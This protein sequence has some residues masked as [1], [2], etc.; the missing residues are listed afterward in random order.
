MKDSIKK[1]WFC[2]I[3]VVVI[4]IA[5]LIKLT[6]NKSDGVGTAG[7]SL[8]EFEEINLGMSNLTVNKIIDKLDEWNDNNI[9]NKCCKE[10]SKSSQNSVYT[11]SYKYYGE[12]GGYAIITFEA[13]YSRGDLFVLP[14]VVKKENFNLK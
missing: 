8:Q 13:D 6:I 4:T 14:S 11:Y 1:W 9:Y 2:G 10:I 5:I 12:K 3:V 7:I